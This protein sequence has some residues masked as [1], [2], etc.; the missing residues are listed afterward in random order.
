MAT[1]TLSLLSAL[2]LAAVAVG[3]ARLVAARRAGSGGGRVGVLAVLAAAVVVGVLV[4][5]QLLV[6]VRVVGNTFDGISFLYYDLVV[7]LPLAAVLVLAGAAAPGALRARPTTPVAVLCGLAL[8]AAPLGFYASRI[9]PFA[10][11]VEH[12]ELALPAARAG[13]QPLRVGVL[14]D[15]QTTNV[16]AYERDAVDRLMATEPDLVLVAGDLFQGSPAQYAAE[17]DGLR[18]VLDRL[19]AAPGGAFVVAGDTDDP[20][21]LA[22]LVGET[23]ATFLADETTE[24]EVGDRSVVVA[25]LSLKV[26]DAGSAAIDELDAAPEGAVRLVVAHRPEQAAYVEGRSVDLVA[27]GHTHGGQ[28]QLPGYGPLITLTEVPQEVAAGGLGEVEGVPT[29]VS[30][31][32]GREQQGAPQVRFLA[33]PSVGVLTLR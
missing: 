4:V 7:A 3:V 29:Y 10:L 26:S 12:A 18:Q 2:L 16:G 1:S 6:A 24:V 14:T 19:A 13:E 11:R 27:A 23:D 33:P 20:T 9:E 17:R 21:E 5:L 15:L 32:V 31:G 22:A 30:T 28:V 25:G 8:L